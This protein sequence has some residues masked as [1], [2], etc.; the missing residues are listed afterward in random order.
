MAELK[1]KIAEREAL[2]NSHNYYSREQSP[3]DNDTDALPPLPAPQPP[4]IPPPQITRPPPPPENQHPSYQAAA[5]ARTAGAAALPF[6]PQQ[7][8]WQQQG[9]P[10]GMHPG[11]QHSHHPHQLGFPIPVLGDPLPPPNPSFPPPGAVGVGGP[12]RPMYSLTAGIPTAPPPMPVAPPIQY[13]Q[14]QPIGYPPPPNT[15]T[16]RVALTQQEFDAALVSIQHEKQMMLAHRDG[17][18]QQLDDVE[19]AYGAL[20]AEEYALIVGN[21]GLEGLLEQ[22]QWQPP[23]PPLPT[24]AAPATGT[25]NKKKRKFSEVEVIDL[26]TSPEKEVPPPPPSPPPPQPD[27]SVLKS[28][29]SGGSL[30]DTFIPE[31]ER[32]PSNLLLKGNY[33]VMRRN[34]APARLFK[35]ILL[36][37]ASISSSCSNTSDISSLLSTF[38]LP[39]TLLGFSF[40]LGGYYLRPQARCIDALL[41]NQSQKEEGRGGGGG[42]SDVNNVDELISKLLLDGKALETLTATEKN[43]ELAIVNVALANGHRAY[44]RSF[45]T[46]AGGSSSKDPLKTAAAQTAAT[47][48]VMK[49]LKTGVEKKPNSQLLWPLYLQIYLS[50]PSITAPQARAVIDTAA[51]QAPG[52]TTWLAAAAAAPT[53]LSAAIILHRGAVTIVK[54]N[55]KNLRKAKLAGVVLDLTLRAVRAVCCASSCCDAVA[56]PPL[57]GNQQQQDE[58]QPHVLSSVLCEWQAA[59]CTPLWAEF[60]PT[61]SMEIETKKTAETAAAATNSL[62]L[63]P[64]ER[65]RILSS[66]ESHIAMLCMLWSTHAFAAAYN[67]LPTSVEHRLGEQQQA[68]ALEWPDPIPNERLP[69]VVAALEQGLQAMRITPAVYYKYIE[70][71]EQQQSCSITRTITTNTNSTSTSNRTISNPIS[72]SSTF[73]DVNDIAKRC[74]V[75][76]VRRFGHRTG[77]KYHLYFPGDGFGTNRTINTSIN[78]TTHNTVFGNGGG[79]GGGSDSGYV[80]VLGAGGVQLT[81]STSLYSGRV[82]RVLVASSHELAAQVLAKEEHGWPCGGDVGLMPS[83]ILR[84]LREEADG[85]KRSRKLDSKGTSGSDMDISSD[86]DD[87]GEQKQHKQQKDGG[88]TVKKSA[89]AMPSPPSSSLW[90]D[91]AKALVNCIAPPTTASTPNQSPSKGST[92]TVLQWPAVETKWIAAGAGPHLPLILQTASNNNS[93]NTGSAAATTTATGAPP[94]DY[95]QVGAVVECI[96]HLPKEALLHVYEEVD[97]RSNLSGTQAAAEICVAL[98]R[99]AMELAAAGVS[100]HGSEIPLQKRQSQLEEDASQQ[101]QQQQQSTLSPNKKKKTRRSGAKITKKKSIARSRSAT[102]VPMPAPPAPASKGPLF[103]D[104]RWFSLLQNA[105]KRGLLSQSPLVSW[106]LP[107]AAGA[108][109]ASTPPAAASL[110]LETIRLT[111]LLSVVSALELAEAAVAVHPL[112]KDLQKAREAAAA[113]AAAGQR[114]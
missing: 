80:V 23:P 20:C 47:E 35:S 105:S 22:Q 50:Q 110:W 5:G 108:L 58:Q 31:Y 53:P 88:K 99:R 44:L 56:Y 30:E 19:G 42:G 54:S 81:G 21:T 6:L 52:Y 24:T 113:A 79:S 111:A 18:L 71:L 13:H 8:Q 17:L 76:T 60:S 27:S 46:L 3:A 9:P 107:V 49:I 94:L 34:Q 78:N 55:E 39:K 57:T 98:L 65:E 68:S 72:L 86:E 29:P 91:R 16:N 10:L 73:A 69:F 84:I 41:K 87:D 28:T 114:T 59:W 92:T 62:V 48:A 102:P 100:L 51:K 93:D 104:S 66:L 83:Q 37:P 33:V 82:E 97:C 112:N 4:S 25:R 61:S 2:K 106:A 26:V 103:S 36:S 15:T 67:R 63:L 85:E 45:K 40:D 14:H 43:S 32:I 90:R 1:K 96:K 7:Q 74:F 89:T 75:D 70:E 77:N 12:P 95:F 101:Q 109:V 38:D 64:N 11:Y